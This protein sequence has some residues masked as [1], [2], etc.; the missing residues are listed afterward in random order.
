MADPA[1]KPDPA[2]KQDPDALQGGSPMAIDAYE[3]DV[4]DLDLDFY[5]PR[6]PDGNPSA[7]DNLFMARVPTYVWAAWDKIDDDTP[8]EIGRLRAWSEPDKKGTPKRK[9]RL[10]LKSNVSAHQG[11]PREYDLDDTN[12]AVKN[13]FIFTESDI[14]GFKNKNKLRKDAADQ[15]IPSYLLRAKVEKPPQ[16]S[17]RGG[18]GRRGRDTFRQ[19][20]PK[21]TAIY[22]RVSQEVNMNPI[23]NPETAYLMA[24]RAQEQVTPKNTTQIIDRF[25]VTHNVVQVGTNQ[26]A[27]AFESFIKDSRTQTKKAK[28]EAKTARMPENELLDKIF[29]CF[30]QYNYWSLKALRSAIPQPE[31]YLRST[32]E[33]VADLHKSGRFANN[34]SLKA[35]H[36]DIGAQAVAE[37]APTVNFADESEDEEM[38]D[39]QI[40]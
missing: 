27:K 4:G 21:K 19:V 26:A 29:Q 28:A 13:T 38:E 18:R 10:L 16:Q 35:E 20:I 5:A 24:V 2:V 25:T 11:L 23:D 37:T 34:W 6:D 7:Q 12:Q 14:E 32:L 31:V 17:S 8:I 3:D 40:Q 30:R 39:V 36:Q 33:K 1:V 22:G 9:M 15:H